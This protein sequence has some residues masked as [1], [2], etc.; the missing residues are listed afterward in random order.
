MSAELTKKCRELIL[1]LE[2]GAVD[3]IGAVTPLTGGVS[4]DIAKIEVGDAAYCTKFALAK[5]K[6][7]ANW[8]APLHRNKAEYEWLKVAAKILPES[9]LSLYGRSE[10]LHG[11]AM[12]YLEGSDVYL[13]KTA[14][15]EGQES[16]GEAASVGDMLG[17]IHAASVSDNFDRS[18][19]H[20]RD[21]FYAL[22]IEPYLVFTASHH[23]DL[24]NPLLTLA[25]ELFASD[26]VLIHGDVSPK[27]I[28][29]RSQQPIML[30]AECATMGDASFDIAFCLNHL[31]LKSLYLPQSRDW[32]LQ[33]V[34]EFWSSYA[35][36]INWETAEA[37]EARVG[38]L[39]PAL[40]L[41]RVDGK[42]PVEYL[43]DKQREQVRQIA[44]PLIQ[45]PLPSLAAVTHY[46][47][48]QINTEHS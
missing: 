6:V 30:D 19:F 41:A 21:D 40:M 23:P 34:L 15:L 9:A 20:N 25:D 24:A 14:L 44:I 48:T 38:R 33:S 16:R 2:L 39:L 31:L 35:L 29:L 17:R 7:A 22:R 32:L 36:H 47:F 10:T 12:E 26:Q 8:Q 46:L 28:L 37:L 13:W 4:S 1:E 3:S 42:S 18:P 5:L 11:F 27:N 45:S 43:D